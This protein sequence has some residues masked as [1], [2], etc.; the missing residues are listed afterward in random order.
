MSP[1]EWAESR[2]Q[3]VPVGNVRQYRGKLKEERLRSRNVEK[4]PAGGARQ[5]CHH[6][7]RTFIRYWQQE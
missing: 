4:R 6:A 3:R 5:C 1:V 2:R 7:Q